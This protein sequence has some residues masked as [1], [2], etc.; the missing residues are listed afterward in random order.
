MVWFEVINM[1]I[2]CTIGSIIRSNP[3]TTTGLVVDIQST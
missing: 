3:K 1:E 2:T